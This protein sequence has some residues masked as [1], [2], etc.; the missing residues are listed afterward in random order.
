[1]N[2]FDSKNVG[3]SIRCRLVKDGV[4]AVDWVRWVHASVGSV[5]TRRIMVLVPCKG[6]KANKYVEEISSGWK[7]L[8]LGV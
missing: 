2:I 7:V 1:M 5:I 6:R 8:E 4:E 3:R